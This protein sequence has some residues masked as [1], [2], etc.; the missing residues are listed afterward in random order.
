MINQ[1]VKLNEK[2][3]QAFINLLKIECDNNTGNDMLQSLSFVSRQMQEIESL[4]IPE[5]KQYEF[6]CERE[7]HPTVQYIDANTSEETS[8]SRELRLKG[9]SLKTLIINNRSKEWH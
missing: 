6:A 4:G 3:M 1:E 9:A 8:V 2:T 5:M 7:L